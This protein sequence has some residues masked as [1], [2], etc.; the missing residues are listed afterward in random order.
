[1]SGSE[2]NGCTGV[3]MESRVMAYCGALGLQGMLMLL[4]LFISMW[5]IYNIG[6]K[7]T[8]I[9]DQSRTYL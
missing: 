5:N 3:I 4:V 2:E 6:S 1:M 9:R 7:V 8:A